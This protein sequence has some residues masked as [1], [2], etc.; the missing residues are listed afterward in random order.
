[1]HAACTPAGRLIVVLAPASSG[2]PDPTLGTAA[3]LTC[4]EQATDQRIDVPGSPVGVVTVSAYL[5]GG[6]GDNRS[7]RVQYLH[8]AGI[9]SRIGLSQ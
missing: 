1:M 7:D 4:E 2:P 6:F 3:V 8:R 9:D 5:I